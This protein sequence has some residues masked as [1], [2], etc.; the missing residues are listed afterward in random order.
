[1]TGMGH[2]DAFPRP[3]PSD[4]FRLGQETFAGTSAN[5]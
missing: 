1:M 4:R 2:H 5:G 3:G